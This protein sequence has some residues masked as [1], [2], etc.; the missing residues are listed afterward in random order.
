VA[1]CEAR[2]VVILSTD[3]D[4]TQAAFGSVVVDRY[5]WIVEESE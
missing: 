4:T 3:D 5:V 2:G 1:R